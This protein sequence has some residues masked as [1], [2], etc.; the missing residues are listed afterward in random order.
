[1]KYCN[2]CVTDLH[3]KVK[4]TKDDI[5]KKTC[6]Y[7]EMPLEVMAARTRKKEIT[8]NRHMLMLMLCENT[9]LTLKEIGAIFNCR[10]HTTV[11]HARDKLIDLASVDRA[12]RTELQM[13]RFHL[14]N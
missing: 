5:I 9:R 3:V 2:P 8:H 1:M 6:D 4:L 12:F 10:D 13:L 14:F 7:F 11:I